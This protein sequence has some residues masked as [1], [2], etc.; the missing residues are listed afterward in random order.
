MLDSSGGIWLIGGTTESVTLAN[1]IA[2]RGMPC[3][4]TVTTTAAKSLYPQTPNLRVRVGRLDTNELEQFL[5]KH[6]IVAI[7]DA[8]HPYAV[9]ISQ[10]AISAACARH[11]PYLRFERQQLNSQVSSELDNSPIIYLNSFQ[12]L[13]AGNYL[14]H[15]RV[16]LTIGYKHLPLFRSWQDQ[17]TL[18]ARILP[19]VTAIDVAIASGFSPNRIIA[20]RPPVPAELEKAL[21][22]HWDISV[23]VTKASGVAGGEDIKRTLANELGISLVIIT[24]PV[25]DYPQQTSNVSV[26]LEFCDRYV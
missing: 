1:A 20:L 12:D 22:H 15:Q 16:L 17:S 24:R 23:V 25:V 26:G 19:S 2:S 4:V 9:E 13:I 8:S 11:I 6:G 21:W 18:Y 3:T 14:H 10:I 5:E 7:L